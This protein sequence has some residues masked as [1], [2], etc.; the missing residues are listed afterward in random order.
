MTH[1]APIVDAPRRGLPT[2]RH[3]GAVGTAAIVLLGALVAW[4]WGAT[5]LGGYTDD[6]PPTLVLVLTVL[7]AVAPALCALAFL[8]WTLIPDHRAAPWL[9]A[10]T[11]LAPVVWWGPSWPAQ[12]VAPRADDLIVMTWNAHRLW[13][14]PSDG[15]NATTCL[16]DEVTASNPQIVVLEEVTLQDLE[17]LKPRLGLDCVHSTYQRADDADSAGI[18]VCARGGPWQL[19]RGRTFAFEEEADWRYVRGVFERSVDGADPAAIQRISVLGVHLHP[20]RILHD[21]R[22]L[23]E[24]AADRAPEVTRAQEAQTEALLAR[25]RDIPEPTI[26]AGDFNSTRDTPFH[27]RLRRYLVDAWERGADG[28]GGTVDLLDVIPLRIDFIY[29]SPRLPVVSAAIPQVGCSDH[30]PVVA[31][32]RAP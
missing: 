7:P 32:L 11:A 29:A 15:G 17:R 12:G 23:L 30:R 1:E 26:I 2:P 4:V 8:L 24:N 5:F 18:A 20:Y 16:V 22:H 21:Q 10:A 27:S 14:G 31:R 3:G 28:F 9:L 13:G 19:Q 25:W 6:V